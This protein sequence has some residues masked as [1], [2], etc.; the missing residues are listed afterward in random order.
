MHN[1]VESLSKAEVMSWLEDGRMS[2]PT[3]L[4]HLAGEYSDAVCPDAGGYAP[5]N[6]TAESEQHQKSRG[7]V[8]SEGMRRLADLV[9]LESVKKSVREVLAYAYIQQRRTELQLRAQPL[10]LHSVFSGNPG[11]GKTTV[12]R[13]LAQIFHDIGVLEKGHL[14]EVERADIV[15]EYI[16]HTAQKMRRKVRESLGGMLFIDE[17]Y[18]LARGGERD[19][20]KEAIDAVVKAME[21]RRDDFVLVLAGYTREM[22]WFLA[23]NPGLRSRC[24]THLVFPDYSTEELVRIA[25]IMLRRRQ[26][27]LSGRARTA[28]WAAA[29][30]LQGREWGTGNA[31][32]MRNLLERAM[33]RQALRLLDSRRVNRE[34][35]QKLRAEDFEE[36]EQ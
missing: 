7:A 36:M 2:A 14:V 6:G 29:D 5:H 31:R 33:R 25:E 10:M 32:S 12:A 3:A 17:A 4:S 23:Q 9:G 28:L 22:E 15:G 30:R 35:L 8:H 20:G 21:D 19:F 24:A 13:I 11:T 26:Y 34:E 18:S 1:S 27:H 16:G